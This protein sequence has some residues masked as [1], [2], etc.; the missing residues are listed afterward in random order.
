LSGSR[1]RREAIFG[2]L[3]A[4]STPSAARNVARVRSRGAVR[5]ARYRP[6]LVLPHSGLQQGIE[7]HLFRRGVHFEQ[8]LDLNRSTSAPKRRCRWAHP[9]GGE[10]GSNIA[11]VCSPGAAAAGGLW[12]SSGS[13]TS[14]RAG[15]VVKA[16]GAVRGRFPGPNRESAACSAAIRGHAAAKLSLPHRLRAAG[17]G[18]PPP[19]VPD[20]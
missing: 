15:E 14:H 12:A 3:S 20:R 16:T 18:S 10:A 4:N 6:H 17:R 5:R 7:Q 11:I 1:L 8:R 19:S 9:H 13:S 2:Y